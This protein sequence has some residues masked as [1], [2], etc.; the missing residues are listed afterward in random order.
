MHGW[1]DS[2]LWQR[3][4]FSK[5]RLAITMDLAGHGN[6]SF[7]REEY[8]MVAFAEDIKAVI[9]KEQLESVILVGHSMRV[10]LLQ[11]PLN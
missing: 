9:D 4:E 3:S 8:T 6:S 5:Q 2:R 11:K 7:N 10:K 1:S